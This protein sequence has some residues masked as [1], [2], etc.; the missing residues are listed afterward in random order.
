MQVNINNSLFTSL[1]Y[2]KLHRTLT[3]LPIY[4]ILYS[5]DYSEY[6]KL[7]EKRPFS[8]AENIKQKV[9]RM[10]LYRIPGFAQMRHVNK[11]SILVKSAL[12]FLTTENTNSSCLISSQHSLYKFNPLT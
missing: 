11:E 5:E 6:L 7:S 2:S 12:K 3:F 1:A 8:R 9:K 4:Y 10:V